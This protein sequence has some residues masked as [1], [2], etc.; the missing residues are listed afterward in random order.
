[1]IRLNRIMSIHHATNILLQN[2]LSQGDFSESE[3]KRTYYELCK[4]T[5]PDITGK[6]SAP[7]LRLQQDYID[8]QEYLRRI[9]TSEIDIEEN[10]N[11][12]WSQFQ[13][14]AERS[15]QQDTS[16]TQSKLRF[17]DFE[18]RTAL[19]LSL[20]RYNAA[21]LHSARVRLKEELRNRNKEILQEVLHWASIYDPEFIPIF[22][23]YNRTYLQTFKRWKKQSQFRLI[24]KKF[25]YGFSSFLNY[26]RNGGTGNTR[27]ARSYL[28]E[29]GTLLRRLS[30]IGKEH[31]AMLH[32]SDW[33]LKQLEQPSVQYGKGFYSPNLRY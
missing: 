11:T 15:E 20:D 12:A 31:E 9:E 27:L 21:G 28:N 8:A 16:Q 1:M 5:H 33:M 3:L 23:E 4:E 6:G 29:T 32:F 7:F 25:L 19:F 26:Q 10:P 17:E 30:P 13:S 22:L 2:L 14:A 24:R 18:P